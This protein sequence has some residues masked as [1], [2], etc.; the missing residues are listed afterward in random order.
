MD[1]D[2]MPTAMR[3]M[4]LGVV[5]HA[6]DGRI[7]A[8][9]PAA[10]AILGL[11]ERQL[12]GLDSHDRR[13]D[14]VDAG[15]HPVPGDRHPVME[16]LATGRSVRDRV[17]GIADA[18]QP[19]G[20][21]WLSISAVPEQGRVCVF[22]R[23]ITAEHEAEE[24]FSLLFAHSPIGL[25]HH[26][27]I[28]DAAGRAVDYLFLDANDHYLALTGVDPR[29]RTVTAAFPG[30]ERDPFDWIGR[31]AR[32]V[33]TGEPLR[34]QQHLPF[35]DRWYDVVAYR[36][37]PEHFVA[38][39]VEI[40]EQKRAELALRAS[41]ENLR[42]TL[43]SIGDAVVATDAQGRV[44]RLNGVAERLTGWT[45]AEAA[46]RPLGE[47][48]RIVNA[49]TRAACDDPVAK[50]LAT[51]EI[52]GL[53]NHTVLLARGGSEYQI[54]DSG[55]PIRAADGAIVGVVLVFR[56]VTEEHA[57]QEQLAQSRKLDS[58]GQLAGGVAHDFNNMLA[59]IVSATE[60]LQRHGDDLQRRARLLGVIGTAA[61]RAADLTR[62]LLA[63]ARKGTGLRV[64]VPVHEAVTGA[65]E[66]LQHSVDKRVVVRQELLAERDLVEGDLA[67]LQSVFLNLGLNAA[68]AMPGGGALSFSSRVVARPAEAQA[69]AFALAAG[70]HLEL[71][72]RDTGCG[73]APDVLPRIFDP[74]FTT[75][76]PG[77]GTGLGLTAAYGTIR[78]HRGAITVASEQGRG[79]VFTIL[80]PLL[81]AGE[82]SALPRVAVGHVLR[83]HG[84]VLVVDDEE[85]VRETAS[86]MLADLGY[87]VESAVDGVDALARFAPGRF[88]LVLLD[89]VMPAMDGPAC[90]RRLRAIDPAIRVV[91]CSGYANDDDPASLQAL[92]V[93]GVLRKPYQRVDLAS[94]LA[95]VMGQ[96]V[97]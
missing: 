1:A 4:P 30:I 72:V 10:C 62:K 5:V 50:V 77:Q 16:S 59:G 15:G 2:W 81:A 84:R 93:Q 64:P 96:G 29:G 48:F 37:A 73:I 25:A 44:Q 12:V 65:V 39:F 38:A 31:F 88:D 95:Q 13:W 71:T 82:D 22:F 11:T 51:G 92:G 24:R 53:A 14:A 97:R 69:E 61:G 18:R 78:H 83:G 85:V 49:H 47:V 6:A 63:F 35:N 32:V 68:H 89:M 43:Q 7:V 34:V 8:A 74:F 67:E 70:P 40:T 57:L 45:Q 27:M 20:R 33:A 90:C 36:T 41:E 76:A 23:D 19:G 42:I 3:E 56:D 66:L 54:A 9:N 28:Y 58:L 46:G 94:V 91:L 79:T 17:L 52:V 87:Q 26:R 21:R 80:L 55:A 60:L 86:L 75:K